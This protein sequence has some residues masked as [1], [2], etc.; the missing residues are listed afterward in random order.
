[1]SKVFIDRQNKIKGIIPIWTTQKYDNL[2]VLKQM[3]AAH[4]VMD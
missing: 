1:M 4:Y 2:A 3:Y